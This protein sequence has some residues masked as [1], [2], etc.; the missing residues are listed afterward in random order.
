MELLILLNLFFF[1][2]LAATKP[3]LGILFIIMALPSYLIRFELFSVP[4][5]LL[6]GMIGI[7]FLFWLVDSTPRIIKTLKHKFAKREKYPFRWEI[8]GIL[9]LSYFAVAISNFDLGAFGIWK[10]YF[11]EPIILF[12]LI[13]NYFPRKKDWQKI[14]WALA[15]SALFISIV[16]LFQ[17][18][19]GAYIFNPYWSQEATRRVVSV[20]GYPNA[21]GLYLAPIIML[22][23]GLLMEKTKE[24][25]NIYSFLKVL[26]LVIIIS[27]SVLSIYFARSEGA[28]IAIL[29][30]I[31]LFFWLYSR[32]SKYLV[33]LVI[34][35]GILFIFLNPAVYGYAKEKVLLQDK[36]GQIR[37]AQWR[38]TALM[39]ESDTNWLVGAGLNNYQQAVTPY[40]V[41]GI[42]IEDHN[43]PD[44]LRKTLFNDEFRQKA[45]QP[46]E[47]Y[48][49]PHNIILNFWTEL[50]I[51]G[52]IIFIWVFIKFFIRS[53][54]LLK[55]DD[56]FWRPLLCGLTAAMATIVIHGI[57]DVPYF[58]NDLS[59][60]FWIM[61]AMLSLVVVH[62]RKNNKKD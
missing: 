13:M 14:V 51:L 1:A 11:F 15:L 5:T 55:K 29:A 17:Q 54:T 20:F 36:S 38:E 16:S 22:S 37:Q 25:K 53:I 47:V 60:L 3:R 6:E 23:I 26:A 48:L 30:A 27:V 41:E 12:I 46:L 10:A 61:L 9:I 28:L 50:G 40:H 31:I 18:F 59:A 19:T 32:W 56:N 45:W 52:L 24:A 58:K 39:L 43:D 8:I 2:V 34:V 62:Q 21:I 42:F 33:G 44:W 35:V 57:V 7:S 4:T 49:Y